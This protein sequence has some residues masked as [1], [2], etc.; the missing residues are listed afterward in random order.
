MQVSNIRQH[1]FIALALAA[2]ISDRDQQSRNAKFG[3]QLE[4]MKDS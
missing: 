4:Q 1:E 3:L 2:Y